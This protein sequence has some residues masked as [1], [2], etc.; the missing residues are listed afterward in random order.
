MGGGVLKRIRCFRIACAVAGLTVAGSAAASA[1]ANKYTVCKDGT[2]W[3]ERGRGACGGHGGV[4]PRRSGLANRSLNP[5]LPREVEIMRRRE[6]ERRMI[7]D[8]AVEQRRRIYESN[9]SVD[10]KAAK[11]KSKGAKPKGKP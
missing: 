8:I 10:T 4:D 2:V 9:G 3:M 5:K 1:Q 6:F 11:S 7:A